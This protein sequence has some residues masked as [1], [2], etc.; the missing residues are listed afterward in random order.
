M[1]KSALANTPLKSIPD[2]CT[3]LMNLYAAN[4]CTNLQN[5]NEQLALNRC[6]D[7]FDIQYLKP[8]GRY[9]HYEDVRLMVETLPLEKHSDL[10]LMFMRGFCAGLLK[11]QEALNS[12]FLKKNESAAIARCS[13][14][15][16]ICQ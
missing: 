15:P 5:L 10:L 11:W 7:L 1:L 9:P 8:I 14:D 13:L 4:M 6:K 2:A 3:E 16:D 12:P